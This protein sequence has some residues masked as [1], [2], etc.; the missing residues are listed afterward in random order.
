MPNLLLIL[1]SS[2]QGRKELLYNSGIIPDQILA[3]N[4]DETPL[5]KEKHLDLV[6]R[7]SQQK[8]EFIAKKFENAI[9]IGADTIVI[10][11]N[12]L[13]EKA[14][15]NTEVESYLN[16]M[17]GARCKVTTSFY[18]IKKQNNIITATRK[19]TITSIIKIKHLTLQEKKLYL[20]TN[21]GLGKAGGITLMGKSSP[22]IKWIRGSVTGIIGLPILE[23]KNMLM[24]LGYDFK[25]SS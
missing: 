7:L 1:A 4:I 21:E 9:I 20:E 18:I 17:S 3:S 13:L 10:C 25:I 19:N 5:K 8:C 24:S 2:S 16:I 11:K 22:F 14:A 6:K 15:N 12:K 23:T